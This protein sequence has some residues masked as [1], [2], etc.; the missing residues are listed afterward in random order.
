MRSFLLLFCFSSLTLFAQVGVNNNSPEQALDVNGKIKMTDDGTT[1]SAGTMR[2]NAA[3]TDFEGYNGSEWKSL[4]VDGG[5]GGGLPSG[6]IPVYGYNNNI[7]V[8]TNEVL[9]FYRSENNSVISG[10]VPAGKFL[11]V[12]SIY[13]GPNNLNPNARLI[14]T[15]MPSN[16]PT[17]GNITRASM[18]FYR[19]VYN[20]NLITGGDAPLFTLL[21]GQCLR[22]FVESGSV[23]L[24]FS[25]QGFLVDDL[26]F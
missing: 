6:A 16:N 15:M 20:S 17:S 22:T 21:S 25:V 7:D 19:D 9:A 11:I 10:G 26:N 2:Y 24:R 23:D 5:G 3:E 14:F 18:T 12:T 13:P 1:P 4:T 8:G